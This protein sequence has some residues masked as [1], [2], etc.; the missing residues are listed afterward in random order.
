MGLSLLI[1]HIILIQKE[2]KGF[3]RGTNPRG[4]LKRDRRS[5]KAKW[6]EKRVRM[7]RYDRDG[8]L[9]RVSSATSNGILPR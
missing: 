4:R 7:E 2:G 3:R 1:F 9:E 6:V 8:K 5:T